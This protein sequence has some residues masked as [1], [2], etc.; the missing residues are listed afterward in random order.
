MGADLIP[1]LRRAGSDPVALHDQDLPDG[2]YALTVEA[3]T[4]KCLARNLDRAES[5]LGYFT[6][7][8]LDAELEWQ[9][10]N[11]FSVVEAD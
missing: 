10:L 3:D 1:D 8:E 11:T 2:D 9:G 5:D 7:E 6:V 4:W